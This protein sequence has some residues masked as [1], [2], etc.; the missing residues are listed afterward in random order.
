MPGAGAW[1][2]PQRRAWLRH[3]YSQRQ[4]RLMTVTGAGGGGHWGKG[5]RHV[6]MERRGTRGGQ[7]GPG[8][9]KDGDVGD[10]KDTGGTRVMETQRVGIWGA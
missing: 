9:T 4:K 8:D 1:D 7:A 2:G 5:T 6:G 3:Y 10:A